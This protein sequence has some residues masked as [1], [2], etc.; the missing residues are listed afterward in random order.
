MRFF[1]SPGDYD[2]H[3]SLAALAGSETGLGK[4]MLGIIAVIFGFALT[5]L[6]LSAFVPPSWSL[7]TGTT[8]A[9]L[10]VQLAGFALPLALLGVVVWSLHGRSFAS[11]FGS[12]DLAFGGFRSV[13]VKVLIVIAIMQAAPP[14][15]GEED[16]AMIRPIATWLLYLPLAVPAVV[17]QV[18][19]EEAF[20]R[21]YIQ[22]QLAARWASPQVWMIAPAVAFGSIH[23]LNA[24]TLIEGIIWS[25]WATLFALSAADLTARHGSLGPAIGLHLANNLFAILF[26]GIDGRASNG[27]AL[28]LVAP[29]EI[30][31]ST[32]GPE[33]LLT[34]W[35]FGQIAL[36]ILGAGIPWLAA[37]LALR[38]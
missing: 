1:Y 33:A 30:D 21:G 28:I 11:L 36:T 25:L 14:W 38:R 18:T 26:F 16:I 32:L 2:A 5:P 15:P 12:R 20:F 22:Q 23:F 13:F 31:L 29:P 27:L 9:G 3:P 7:A 17:I 19:A 6:V 35:G 10:T 24:E 37:R 8:A 4:T 34:P